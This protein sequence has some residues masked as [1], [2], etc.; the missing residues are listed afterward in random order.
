MKNFLTCP[1][2]SYS[3]VRNVIGGQQR[4]ACMLRYVMYVMNA[5]NMCSVLLIEHNGFES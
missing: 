4:A 3:L 5:V 1:V 2:I